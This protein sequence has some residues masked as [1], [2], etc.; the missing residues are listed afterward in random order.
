MAERDNTNHECIFNDGVKELWIP[1]AT[2]IFDHHII[3]I[4][5]LDK[6]YVLYLEGTVGP[7]GAL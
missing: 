4:A 2:C 6:Q 3:S 7:A 5:L 1:Y